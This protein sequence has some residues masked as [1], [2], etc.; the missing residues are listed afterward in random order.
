MA[1]QSVIFLAF[2]N[3]QSDPLLSLEEE[4][5]GVYDA[6][7]PRYLQQHYMLHRDSYT[8]I[9]SI[10][11]YLTRFKNEIC[12][13]LYSG[14]AGQHALLLDEEKAYAEG[15]AKL[16]G[17]CPQLKAVILNG[18]STKGQV[19]LLLKEGV[20]V[21]IATSAAINDRS[22]T[23]FSIHFFQALAEN[24]EDLQAAFETGIGAAQMVDGSLNI[25]RDMLFDDAGFLQ[26][27]KPNQSLWGLYNRK[28]ADLNWPLPRAK[29]AVSHSDYQPNKVLVD[30][31]SEAL[32]PYFSE[33]PAAD[34]PE[35][36]AELELLGLEPIEVDYKPA[37]LEC[38]P[39][40]VGEHLRKLLVPEVSSTNKRGTFYD[41]LGIDRLKQ[42]V[43]TYHTLIE[44]VSFSMMA[45]LWDVCMQN[46]DMKAF[47]GSKTLLKQFF[48]LSF[49]EKSTYNFHPLIRQ[50]HQLFS[51]N[52][53]ASFIEELDQE[54]DLFIEG[55]DAYQ[56]SQFFEAIKQK[57]KENKIDEGEA[58]E[59]CIPAEE[60]L[61]GI[62]SALHFIAKYKLISVRSIDILNYRHLKE[63]F[64]A[65]KMVDIVQ[66]I[67]S[68]LEEKSSLK[69]Q[70]LINSSVLLVNKEGGDN[71]LNLSPFIVDENTFTEKSNIPKLHFFDRYEAT[72]DSYSFR[73]VYKP[74]DALLVIDKQKNFQVLK[75]QF[76]AFSQLVFQQAMNAI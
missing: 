37:I 20:P 45:Q 42:M 60:K 66:K 29:L 11:K 51:S 38:L 72:R 48:G 24:Y 16:L 27:E 8:S 40:P 54:E 4:D 63:P 49:E 21:V 71:I 13:F 2:A 34:E 46:Q 10:S 32:K 67:G 23:Q 6:L 50:L 22:A 68:V 56:A 52:K 25:H 47:E 26:E 65:H 33:L 12:L 64:Y 57:L 69:K 55:S 18:C 74:D 19:E 73:H 31:L 59:L 70:L 61:A 3:S 17:Q 53:V 36:L 39:H 30:R 9:E 44:L 28:E 75:A 41:K 76:N 58:I 15:V 43:E 1:K 5:N 62:L 35:D 14:H 7:S